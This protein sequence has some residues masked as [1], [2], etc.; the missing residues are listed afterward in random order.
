MADGEQASSAFRVAGTVVIGLIVLLVL[1]LWRVGGSYDSELLGAPKA[2]AVLKAEKKS[3]KKDKN[4]ASKPPPKPSPQVRR[5][6]R[7]VAYTNLPSFS[8]SAVARSAMCRLDAFESWCEVRKI[9][10]GVS[11]ADVDTNLLHA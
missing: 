5:A 4:S 7:A 10:S 2:P 11:L 8:C 1:I 3:K 6:T 9:R